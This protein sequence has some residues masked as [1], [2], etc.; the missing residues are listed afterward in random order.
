MDPLLNRLVS[1][2]RVTAELL[3]GPAIARDPGVALERG[4]YLVTGCKDIAAAIVVF[5]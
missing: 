4:G 2:E 1:F 5:E 3:R